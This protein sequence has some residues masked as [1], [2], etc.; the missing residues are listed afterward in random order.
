MEREGNTNGW[1]Y[2]YIYGVS[3]LRENN[4][5]AGRNADDSRRSREVKGEEKNGEDKKIRKE[6]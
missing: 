2:I 5:Q 4:F 1:I 6:K 3:S